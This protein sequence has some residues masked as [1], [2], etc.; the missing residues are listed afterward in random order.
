MSGPSINQDVMGV[1]NTID[2]CGKPM[3]SHIGIDDVAVDGKMYRFYDEG[4]AITC[5]QIIRC[6]IRNDGKQ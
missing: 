1:S 2:V 6:M 5:M 4:V 3:G